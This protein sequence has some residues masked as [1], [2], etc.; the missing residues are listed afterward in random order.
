MLPLMDP[1]AAHLDREQHIQ[2]AL[3]HRVDAEEVHRQDTFGLGLKELPPTHPRP[4]RRRI[5]P[6]TLEEKS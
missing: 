1:P 4:P 6:G 2:P 3:Q 5:H